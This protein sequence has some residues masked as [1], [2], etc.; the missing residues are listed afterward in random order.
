M[1]QDRNG[2]MKQDRSLQYVQDIC[3]WD[4]RLWSVGCFDT[5]A[6]DKKSL[7]MDIDLA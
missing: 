2:S 1:R 5:K 3:K 7:G 4:L 6:S